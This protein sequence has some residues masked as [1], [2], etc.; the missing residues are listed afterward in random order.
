MER[1][2]NFCRLVER[3]EPSG[4]RAP[5]PA[6]RLQRSGSS[7]RCATTSTRRRRWR[8]CS[9][10][11]A[12]ATAGSRRAAARR[13][14]LRRDA[15]R[16]RPRAPAR[17]RRGDGRRGGPAAA[18]PS[19]SEAAPR[20]GLRRAPTS[21][22]T[23]CSS[24][25]TRCATRP[26]GPELVPRGPSGSLYGRN[27]VARGAARAA[28][29]CC[30]RLARRERGGAR[31]AWLRAATAR[32]GDAADELERALR[33]ARPPGPRAP[34]SS[35][36]RTPTPRT[37]LRARGRAGRRA[38][39]G[40]GPAEPG[41]DL[42]QRRGA[43]A[44][45]VVIP[46]RARRRGHAG[47]LPRVGGRGRAPAGRA[48]AQPRGLPR[49]RPRRRAPGSTAP[50]RAR[51]RP[52]RSPTRRARSCSCSARREG[53]APARA[54]ACDALVSLPLRGQDRSLNVSAAAA[55]LLYEASS[56]AARPCLDK[57]DARTLE[58]RA[59]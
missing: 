18:Q 30:A 40:P 5:E 42:P 45:G 59:T 55:A 31:S 16:A 7:T 1:I 39:P 3:S 6:A 41:R 9:S 21:C 4:D 44:T 32:S 36:I 12:R 15:R 56:A 10:W 51:G 49:A 25:A 29:G 47:G 23:S 38:G 19:A 14:A 11:S 58:C 37:L 57:S 46:E 22:A 13:A 33:V 20:A 8:R 28:G 17:R 54:R 53:A 52:T 48:G 50:R 26:E 34:R 24:A 2:A 35:P 27:A 43:G